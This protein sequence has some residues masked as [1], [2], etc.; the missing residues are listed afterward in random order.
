MHCFFRSMFD[1]YTK[2]DDLPDNID[3]VKPYYQSL[4]DKYIPGKVKF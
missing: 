3:E 4:I 2:T 1:V